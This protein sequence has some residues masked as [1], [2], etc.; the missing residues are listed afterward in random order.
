MVDSKSGGI[1]RLPDLRIVADAAIYPTAFKIGESPQHIRSQEGGLAPA[2]LYYISKSETAYLRD[3]T[4][5]SP[6]C[7]GGVAAAS[8]DGA[9]VQKNQT[10]LPVPPAVAGGFLSEP[11][12]VATG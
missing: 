1:A 11:G 3:G 12:A 6:P 5:S 2:L 7:L 4:N 10:L 8:A 9:V